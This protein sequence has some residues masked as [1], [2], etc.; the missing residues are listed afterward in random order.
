MDKIATTLRTLR[1][2]KAHQVRGFEAVK[3]RGVVAL[4]RADGYSAHP[5]FG[6]WA[7]ANSLFDKGGHHNQ[8]EQA[9]LSKFLDGQRREIERC[10]GLG[11]PEIL[12]SEACIDVLPPKGIRCERLVVG[13]SCAHTLKGVASLHN[14]IWGVNMK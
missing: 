7:K 9:R 8:F 2:P 10:N 13:G 11:E 14:Q 1:D 3:T 4:N 12:F 6:A 5:D